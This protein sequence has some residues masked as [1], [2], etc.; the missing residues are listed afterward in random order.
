[1]AEPISLSAI[2][3]LVVSQNLKLTIG[4]DGYVLWGPLFRPHRFGSEDDLVYWLKAA[5]EERSRLEKVAEASAE[6]SKSREELVRA[7][8]R[9]AE[10]EAMLGSDLHMPIGAPREQYSP[11]IDS[12][13]S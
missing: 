7:Q 13:Y 12:R 6:L 3:H 2:T 10:L 9:I 11:M 1:M 8:A 5:P 4:Y